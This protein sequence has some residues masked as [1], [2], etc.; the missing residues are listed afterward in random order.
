[1]KIIL[2]SNFLFVPLQFRIDIFDGMAGLLKQ[3]FEPILLSTTHQEL[4][5]MAERGPPKLRKQAA[6]ALRLAEK[7]SVV[8]V[9]KGVEEAND[10]VIVRVASQWR[11]PVATNDSELRRRLRNISI[12]VVY[13]RQKSRLELEGSV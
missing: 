12:P 1:M 8:D 5:R 2:D 10:D 6:T 3:R 13:V 7:C 4:Q 11:C 9:E